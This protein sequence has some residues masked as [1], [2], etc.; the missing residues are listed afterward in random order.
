MYILGFLLPLIVVIAIIA[1]PFLAKILFKIQ[2]FKGLGKGLCCAFICLL[3]FIGCIIIFAFILSKKLEKYTN[4]RI[5]FTFTFSEL[6]TEAFIRSELGLEYLYFGTYILFDIIN[7]ALLLCYVA[8]FKKEM[9]SKNQIFMFISGFNIIFSLPFT[10]SMYISLKD[11]GY[12][13]I[14]AL[15][16]VDPPYHR[17]LFAFEF[18]I[19]SYLFQLTGFIML[20]SVYIRSRKCLALVLA[21]VTL[22][23]PFV[24]L[25]IS[26]LIQ[27]YIMSDF[28]TPITYYASLAL[29]IIFYIKEDDIIDN[30]Q[31]T[32]LLSSYS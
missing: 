32:N 5:P 28:I 29:G 8:I 3:A 20:A 18:L 10:L 4:I 19:I 11:F 23:L 25:I 31:Q 27:S 24:I 22:F 7:M 17:I 14:Q 30:P 6:F 13:D 26:I 21:I 1:S 15:Y 9:E 12:D 16:G 2:Y